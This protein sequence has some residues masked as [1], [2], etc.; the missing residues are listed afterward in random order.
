MSATLTPEIRADLVGKVQKFVRDEIPTS[1]ITDGLSK[2]LQLTLGVSDFV[3]LTDSILSEAIAATTPPT[4]SE[5][6][7]KDPICIPAVTINNEPGKDITPR[8][9]AGA[10][11][12]CRCEARH[13]ESKCCPRA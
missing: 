2:H 7:K 13:D 9:T 12:D 3:G 11:V 5:T 10:R 6:P 4:V 1:E 8:E